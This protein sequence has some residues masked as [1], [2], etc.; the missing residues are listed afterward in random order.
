MFLD[1]WNDDYNINIKDLKLGE[2]I[3]GVK[4]T[5]NFSIF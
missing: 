2:K 3:G 1:W 5:R 4:K